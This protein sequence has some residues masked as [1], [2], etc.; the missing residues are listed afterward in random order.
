MLWSQRTAARGVLAG[1]IVGMA[2]G[3][4]GPLVAS[5]YAGDPRLLQPI[6]ALVLFG[7]VLGAALGGVI[8]SFLGLTRPDEPRRTT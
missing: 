3:V 2:L 8:G 7:G 6:S 5:L 1:L 4:L